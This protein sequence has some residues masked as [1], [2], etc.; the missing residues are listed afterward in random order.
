[1]FIVPYRNMPF[2]KNLFLEY[3]SSLIRSKPEWGAGVLLVF[4]EQTDSRPFNRGAMKNIG[5][6]AARLKFP[7][8]WQSLTFVFHDVDSL[9]THAA[10]IDF[11]CEPGQVNH[12]YGNNTSLGGVFSIRARDFFRSGG[13]PN[14]WGWGYEDNQMTKRALRAGLTICRLNKIDI[15]DFSKVSRTDRTHAPRSRL[16]SVPDLVRMFRGSA[17]G[18]R[19]IRKLKYVWDA[20]TLRV[21][22]FQTKYP[23]PSALT[24]IPPHILRGN[25]IAWAANR[26]S[27]TG[28][29]RFA[30]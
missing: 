7:S 24:E 6:I 18:L 8:H 25:L 11:S 27:R 9:L 30:R 12:I 20:H 21:E 29:M 15:D 28:L 1:M 16:V 2:H 23:A 14:A 22:R 19:H 4:S 10:D 26:S 5:A 3:F 13:F 17:D